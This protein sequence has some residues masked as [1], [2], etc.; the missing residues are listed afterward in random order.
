M[1]SSGIDIKKDFDPKDVC[2]Q[3]P[4]EASIEAAL[5]NSADINAYATKLVPPLFSD[6]N[7]SRLK[8][9]T[10]EVRFEGDVYW[11]QHTKTMLD[12]ISPFTEEKSFESSLQH[13]ELGP[14]DDFKIPPNSIVFVVPKTYF[15]VPPF[16]ALRFNLHINLVHQGLLLGTGPLVDPGFAGRLMIP[17]HNLTSQP[18]VVRG[19]RGFIWIEI[20]KLS[21]LRPGC[22]S[23]EFSKDKNART[24]KQYFFSANGLRPIVSTLLITAERLQ[25]LARWGRAIS[26]YASIL[27]FLSL[28]SVLYGGWSLLNDAHGYVTSARTEVD[29]A[30]TELKV[31]RNAAREMLVDISNQRANLQLELNELKRK[32]QEIQKKQELSEGRR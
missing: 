10:Y 12:R 16:L 14:D 15:R 24:V 6:Y 9:A 11:W 1:S 26:I 4:F 29:T 13:K 20:T 5:L 25:D 23:V 30:L 28:I 17:V 27:F 7:R 21:R 31:E 8:P 19:D 2:K 3:D 22:K 18:V 32:E